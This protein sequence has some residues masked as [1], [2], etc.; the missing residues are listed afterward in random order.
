MWIMSK[1]KWISGA[2]SG[3]SG[4]LA[5]SY[6]GMALVDAQCGVT[7]LTFWL[8]LVCSLGWT[9]NSILWMGIWKRES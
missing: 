8:H 6:G 2:V 7:G 1:N 4:L 3:L 5:V 9:A